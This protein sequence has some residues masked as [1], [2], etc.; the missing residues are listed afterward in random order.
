MVRAEQARCRSGRQPGRR[1]GAQAART[2]ARVLRRAEQLFARKG[3]R[4]VSLRELARSCS[5]RVFTIQHHFGSKLGLYEEI[6]RR[7][8]REVEE[9][10]SRVLAEW[11]GRPE[12]LAVAVDRLFDFFLQ[13]RERLLLNVR[14]VLGE[15]LPRRL[16]L[17]D[18]GWV[19]FMSAAMRR[20][21]IK[22]RD[23]D[24][25]L[26]MITIE[27][28]LN[29][30]VLSAA[31]YRLLFGRDVDDRRLAA[32]VKGHLQRVI[33]AVLGGERA[34]KAGSQRGAVGGPQAGG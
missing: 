16:V 34:E 17:E 10:V 6:L 2:R 14:A 22:L 29:N 11:G 33:A 15:G 24:P 4:G 31:H 13:N 27:G 1:S 19:N 23:V 21:R 9:T 7:W 28:I 5:V 3:Y 12:L 32:R 25:R 30:H 26:L 20:G 18:R 8:D